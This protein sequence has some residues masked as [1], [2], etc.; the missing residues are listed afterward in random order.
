[1][2]ISTENDNYSLTILL[3]VR[4]LIKVVRKNVFAKAV[5]VLAHAVFQLLRR[6]LIL[7]KVQHDANFL[8]C[9]LVIL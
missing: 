7:H 9:D 2:I 4:I 1:M 6:D 8:G 5:I 3:P